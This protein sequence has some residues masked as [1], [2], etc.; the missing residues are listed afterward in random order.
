M[1]RA[2]NIMWD[3]DEDEFGGTA[4]F[5]GLPDHVDIPSEIDDE[6]IA[7]YLSDTYDFCVFGFDIEEVAS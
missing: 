4:L 3:Y 1:R 6:D 2:T 5:L 7:D